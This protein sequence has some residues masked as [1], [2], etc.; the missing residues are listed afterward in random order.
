MHIRMVF[1]LQ[2]SEERTEIVGVT[3]TNKDRQRDT[4]KWHE[5]E[6][7]MVAN[8]RRQTRQ[9]TKEVDIE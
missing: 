5:E 7:K 3:A 2:L 1:A 4:E 6:K 9:Q 8:D